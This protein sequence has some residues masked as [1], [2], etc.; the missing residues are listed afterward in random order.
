[1]KHYV[2]VDNINSHLNGD[3]NKTNDELEVI[4]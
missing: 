1:M 4:L 3:F 2:L